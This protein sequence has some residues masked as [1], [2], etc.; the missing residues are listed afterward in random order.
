MNSL[1]ERLKK[2]A[3]IRRSIPRGEPDRISDI[4]EEA[5]IE[6]D[7]YM[8]TASNL[9]IRVMQLEAENDKLRTDNRILLEEVAAYLRE[10]KKTL[11][12]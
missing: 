4:L 7:K 2:R 1:I 12:K 9:G 11:D 5:A 6:L 3:E 8:K 10:Y